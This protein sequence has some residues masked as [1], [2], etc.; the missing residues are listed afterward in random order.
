MKTQWTH[1]NDKT[2]T[3]LR[4]YKYIYFFKELSRS[5]STSEVTTAPGETRHDLVCQL[6]STLFRARKCLATSPSVA[7]CEG[8]HPASVRVLRAVSSLPGLAPY[9]RTD[10]VGTANE[11]IS[12][13]FL[14]SISIS[15]GQSIESD[16]SFIINE[17][18]NWSEW[19]LLIEGDIF[20]IMNNCYDCWW[21]LTETD[22]K[23]WTCPSLSWSA[24]CWSPGGWPAGR[25]G[26]GSRSTRRSTRGR[27]W[28]CSASSTTSRGT[29]GHRLS[30]YS[31][32]CPTKYFPTFIL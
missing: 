8:S 29:A 5:I 16:L 13:I 7:G 28:C 26:S 2:N 3:L 25:P 15:A 18:F 21:H 10:T 22:Q 24:S 27:V 17:G 1:T 19:L 31:R 32:E 12:I 23:W 9:G 20:Q 11:I 6:N 4:D 14:I 30:T